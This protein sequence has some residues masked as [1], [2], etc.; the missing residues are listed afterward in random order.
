MYTKAEEGIEYKSDSH[1]GD[2]IRTSDADI[3]GANSTR[4][5]GIFK[6]T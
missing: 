2:A 3:Y 1:G 5:E 4:K 6:K